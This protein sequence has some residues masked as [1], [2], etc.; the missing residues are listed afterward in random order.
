MKEFLAE[1]DRAAVVLG[2][3]KID[4]LLGALLNH[5]LIPNPT[6]EDDLLEGDSPLG[7]FSARIKICHR[8]G[9][10]D[11]QFSKLLHIFR[12]LRNTFAHEVTS[13][14]LSIGS[15]RD[16]TM[17][18]AAPF[19][20]SKFYNFVLGEIAGSM[21]RTIDDPGV[22]FRT[23][24]A[25]FHMQLQ[26]IMQDVKPLSQPKGRGIVDIVETASLDE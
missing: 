22:M 2:A 6:T 1:T 18:L 11:A 8:L 17:A 16:R 12:R 21:K 3:A 14:S 19:S 10:I 25:I 7:A 20:D 9:L 13:S 15:A 23:V 26:L 5:Y 24:L 4:A